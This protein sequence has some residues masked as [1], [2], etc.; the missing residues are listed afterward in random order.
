MPFDGLMYIESDTE[1]VGNP[2]ESVAV[3][4]NGFIMKETIETEKQP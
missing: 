1:I 3:H 4:R 2:M